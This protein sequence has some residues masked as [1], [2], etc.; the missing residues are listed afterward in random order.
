MRAQELKSNFDRLESELKRTK[1]YEKN[2]SD[3]PDD[4]P[5]I[6]DIAVVKREHEAAKKALDNA[7]TEA[8]KELAEAKKF[9]EKNKVAYNAGSMAP[10]HGA[11]YRTNERRIHELN[12]DL[13]VL[14]GKEKPVMPRF[15]KMAGAHRENV[16]GN[17]ASPSAQSTQTRAQRSDSVDENYLRDLPGSPYK[18]KKR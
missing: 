16:A 7:V 12:R 5:R 6:R 2:P 9:H 17:R 13:A 14:K 18:S 11:N 4:F 1:S 3:Y 8:K 15:E 10:G